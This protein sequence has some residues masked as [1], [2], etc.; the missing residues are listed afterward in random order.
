[1]QLFFVICLCVRNTNAMHNLFSF[2]LLSICLC[3]VRVRHQKFVMLKSMSKIQTLIDLTGMY[4]GALHD[5]NS[6]RLYVY[7][8]V[9]ACRCL[10]MYPSVLSVKMFCVCVFVCT[11]TLCSVVGVHIFRRHNFSHLQ[12]ALCTT[13]TLLSLS[14]FHTLDD[15]N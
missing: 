1:M 10:L 7:V 6:F 11:I 14:L 9:C 12:M 3:C 5:T 2:A 4:T 13:H 15:F 8:Y